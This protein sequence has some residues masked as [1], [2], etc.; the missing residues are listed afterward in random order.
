[1]HFR[2]LTQKNLKIIICNYNNLDEKDPKLQE[3]III[4]LCFKTNMIE[5]RD[6]KVNC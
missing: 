5:I 1:M 2:K 3:E 4:V 6:H